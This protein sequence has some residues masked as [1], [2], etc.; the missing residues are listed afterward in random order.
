MEY[1][2]YIIHKN[3][4]LCII[5]KSVLNLVISGMPSIQE[6]RKMMELLIVKF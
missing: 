2:Q 5:Q 3:I 4:I 6:T 1:L